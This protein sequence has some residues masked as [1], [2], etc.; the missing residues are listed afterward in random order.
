M[1]TKKSETFLREEFRKIIDDANADAQNF[2][3]MDVES[4]EY[5]AC[6]DER[7]LLLD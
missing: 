7:P 3:H 6:Y 4:N 2:T 5:I 1:E